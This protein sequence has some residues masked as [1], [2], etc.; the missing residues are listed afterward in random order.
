[1]VEKNLKTTDFLDI[2]NP[3]ANKLKQAP[4]QK[5]FEMPDPRKKVDSREDRPIKFNPTG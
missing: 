5:Q 4:K 3:F 1:M 2:A